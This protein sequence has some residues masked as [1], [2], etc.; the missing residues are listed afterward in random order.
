MSLTSCPHP[1][2]RVRLRASA[3]VP[4]PVPVLR[5]AASGGG[6]LPARR[7]GESKQSPERGPRA[8]A[9]PRVLLV[10]D[11]AAIR[12]LCRVNLRLAGMEVLEAA[13]GAVAVEL[14]R[15]ERPDLILLDVMMPEVDGW[16]VVAALADDRATRDIPIVFLTAR[17]ERVDQRRGLEAGA[18]AY[19]TKPFDP[20]SLAPF[21]QTLLDRIERGER[22][23]VR[24]EHLEQLGPEP[25]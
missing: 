15:R 18:V 3:A 12:L 16:E 19:V 20:V 22:D 17:S 1:T 7:R 11:E 14:A 24:A 23:A 13:N 10:D 2:R 9:P 8:A 6:R 4:V 21:L 5:C 25:A